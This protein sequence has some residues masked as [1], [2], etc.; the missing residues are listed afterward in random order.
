MEHFVA[1]VLC[2]IKR[3]NIQALLEAAIARISSKK[4]VPPTDGCECETV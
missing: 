3:V 2:I 1:N 4:N